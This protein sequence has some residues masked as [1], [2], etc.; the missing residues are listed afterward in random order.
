[1]ALVT[2][3]VTLALELLMPVTLAL[4]TLM[5]VTLAPVAMALV[6]LMLVTSDFQT[7]SAFLVS[8]LLKW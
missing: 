7:L 4:V 8:I 6:V 3:F 1:M 2:L 5:F